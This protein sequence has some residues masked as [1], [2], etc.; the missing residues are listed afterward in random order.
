MTDQIMGYGYSV[1]EFNHSLHIKGDPDKSGSPY[2]FMGLILE[3]L[4]QLGYREPMGAMA[5]TAAACNYDYFPV[6]ENDDGTAVMVSYSDI[7]KAVDG[8]TVILEKFRDR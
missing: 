6:A 1:K 4:E 5:A 7:I 3:L 8:N 2:A